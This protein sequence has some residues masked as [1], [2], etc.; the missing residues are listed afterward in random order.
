MIQAVTSDGSDQPFHVGPLPWTCWRTEDFL[1]AHASDSLLELT[2][3]DLVTIA[4]Q[5]PWCSI[6]GKRLYHLLSC[7][8]RRRMRRH[9]EMNDAPAMMSQDHKHEQHPKADGRHRE[10]VDRDQIPHMVVQESLPYLGKG[11]PVLGYHAGN[12]TLGDC[13]SQFEQFS[14]NSGSP[15]LT[16]R[17]CCANSRRAGSRA[18]LTSSCRVTGRPPAQPPKTVRLATTPSAPQGPNQP[19]SRNRRLR[20][21][22][23]GAVVRPGIA[24]R[25][26]GEPEATGAAHLP[27]RM[28]LSADAGGV[29]GD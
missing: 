6:F 15:L 27:G 26:L 18:V 12:R 4:Q 1:E 20:N 10:E 23:S 28:R 17:T 8:T 24:G 22:A 16:S 14:M 29:G 5:V 11:L 19:E 7:P 25:L 9:V 21:A 2:P 3:I 13:D